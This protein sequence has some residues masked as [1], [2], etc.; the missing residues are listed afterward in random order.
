MFTLTETAGAHLAELLAGAEAPEDVF[1][2]LEQE[3]DGLGLRFDNA[4]SGDNKFAHKDR[5]VLVLDDELCQLLA[6]NTLD[7]EDTDD[8]PR[9][10]M[11]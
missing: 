4:L 8:G 3:E 2:R 11:R 6:D 10:H 5:T 1:V 9:L 7:V